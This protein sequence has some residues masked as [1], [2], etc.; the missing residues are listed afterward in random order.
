MP[1]AAEQATKPS[2]SGRDAAS[3]QAGEGHREA[4]NR[5]EAIEAIINGA[6]PA[7]TSG[8]TASKTTTKP[9]TLDH[10]QIEQ[11]RTHLAELRK[12]LNKSR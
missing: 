8:D 1:A 10:A 9:G 4:M 7:G 11:I 6:S 5:I 3:S 2:T 12:E